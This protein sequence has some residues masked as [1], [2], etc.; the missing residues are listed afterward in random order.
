VKANVKQF[1][2]T[3]YIME[4]KA[5]GLLVGLTWLKST[6][7][8]S[9]QIESDCLQVVQHISNKFHKMIEYGRLIY[10]CYHLLKSMENSKISFVR[11]QTNQ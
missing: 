6:N 10:K 8:G 9:M 5:M 1:E 7:I 4:A 3:P 11:R 2:G